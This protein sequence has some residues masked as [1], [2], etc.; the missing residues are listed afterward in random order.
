MVLLP[1]N[2][3]E[4]M[5]LE[6]INKEEAFRYLG[7]RDSTPDERVLSIADKCE[8]ELLKAIDGRYVYKY[9]DIAET[10]ALSEA[11]TGGIALKGT[12]L[13]LPG[14]SIR[15][16][17][18]GCNGVVLFVA[19]LSDKVDLLIR[20][21]NVK[22]MSSAVIVDAMAGAAIEQ[23]C[24]MV[25]KEILDKFQG[26]Y[27]TWRFSPGYGDLPLELQR[28]FLNILEAPKRIG[29]NITEGGL[30]AP[31]KSVSAIIGLSD[32]MIE[33]KRQGCIVCNMRDKCSFRKSGGH[34]G[35]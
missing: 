18:K 20:R 22:Q 23:L 29:V 4:Y 5:K 26:K 35:V 33:R 1:L 27:P 24:D 25:E 7:Y 3:R 34:C 12:K 31:V 9:F 32:N 14:N 13:E 17:L 19:T 16:H 21:L 2:H 6:Y 11:G 30:M 28:E 15:E 10:E 8:E